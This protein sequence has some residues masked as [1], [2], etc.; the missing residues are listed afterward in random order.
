MSALVGLLCALVAP[1]DAW[2]AES[3]PD[4]A[5]KRERLAKARVST[6]VEFQHDDRTWTKIVTRLTVDVPASWPLAQDLLLSE[7]SRRYIKAMSCLTRSEQKTQQRHWAEWR[8]GYPAV[9]SKGGRVKVVDRAH[10]WVD[11]YR[12]DLH[13]GVWTVR[14]GAERWF[15]RLQVP[16]ALAGAQ[17]D[18]ITVDPGEPGAESAKPKPY[19]GQG[20]TALVW[21]PQAVA[22]QKRTAE[23]AAEEGSE[24]GATESKA[25]EKESSDRQTAMARSV[26]SV[27]VWL[28]PSWQRSWAAQND[29]LTV[30]GL[31]RFGGLLWT[32][33]T[34]ALLLSAARS[35]GGRSGNPTNR[36]R[37]TRRNLVAWAWVSAAIDV[38]T[39]T[40]DLIN[41]YVQRRRDDRWLDEWIFHGHGLA[42]TVALLL[43]VLARPP[44]RIWAVAGLL[45]LLP[46]AAMKWPERFD[47]RPLRVAPAD[48][49]YAASDKALAAQTASACCLMALTL[50]GFVAAIWRLATDGQLLPESRR[51][52]GKDRVL[53][54]RVVL[55]AVLGATVVIAV[56]AALTHER[57]WQRVSWLS[58]SVDAVYGKDHRMKLLGDAL[59]S[60]SNG[61]DWI[62]SYNWMLTGVAA[63]A[64]LR[65]W[66]ISSCLSPLDRPPG[67]WA[68]RLLFLTFFPVAVG[69]G[70]GWPLAVALPASMWIPLHMLALY[71][72]ATFF[73][74]RS[75][76]A[77]PLTRSGHALAEVLGPGVRTE[78]LSRARTYRETHATLRRLDQG[79]FG[80]QPPVREEE[81][82]KL[83][84]LHD[85]PANGVLT[86]PDRLPAKVSVVDAALALGPRDT[87]WA[88][89]SRGARFAL[90]PGLPAAT[91]TTWA[92]M[93]RG[94]AWESTLSNQFGFP[95]MVLTLVYWMVTWAGAGFVLGALWRVL[96]GRRGAVKALPVTLAFALPAVLDALLAWF[97]REGVSNLALHVSAMLFVL[98]VTGIALD[99][100]T[101]Q[102]ERRYWQSRLGLLLSV[103]QMRYYS[104]QVAYLVAQIIAMITIWQ[105]FAEPAVTPEPAES[106]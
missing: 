2:A 76:L 82:R 61:Q 103:Y 42:L 98:T 48:Y 49:V 54:L 81:E 73:A 34:S 71:W 80:D 16:P 92:W 89:G 57:T 75:V 94:E 43:L 101:F 13:V 22:Q 27:T 67:D 19:A 26:P 3:S 38:L 100:D 85:W 102:G 60:V 32:V 14:A 72:A 31:D 90:I 59:W 62:T 55:P 88:N 65:A 12:S 91:L 37:H 58:E 25:G 41:R 10:S 95:E 97:T 11:Q 53:K 70:G 105:F 99:L 79:L 87:W 69:L 86:V 74:S 78:L 9:T 18:R 96:P 66:H 17:W 6:S 24:K 77:Q 33:V 63:L 20:A 44:R 5:C 1:A 7:D 8:V 104:L 36:Q 51:A 4:D 21:R 93:V 35:Y 68:A 56:C 52:P 30:V 50:L 84:D 29:R 83:S 64:A 39:L 15:V 46:L 23:K 106:K 47:L 45:A 40:D 28:R